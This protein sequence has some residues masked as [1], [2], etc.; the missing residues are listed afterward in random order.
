MWNP[1]IM[2]YE[3]AKA[4]L[5]S[6]GQTD[7]IKLKEPIGKPECT[8][9]DICQ[10]Y[11]SAI[12]YH[13]PNPQPNSSGAPQL[14]FLAL[15]AISSWLLDSEENLLPKTAPYRTDMRTLEGVN[16]AIIEAYVSI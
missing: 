16:L 15:T 8:F 13:I 12:W 3:K 9:E 5:D 14:Q 6:V 2:K 11:L 4:Y 10:G 7:V 1:L